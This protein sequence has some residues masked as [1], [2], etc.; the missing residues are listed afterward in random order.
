MSVWCTWL[1]ELATLDT[2]RTPEG[3]AMNSSIKSLGID[4]LPVEERLI[5]VEEIW[6]SIAA[7]SATARVTDAQR[8]ELQ[9]RIEEDDANRDD[10]APWEQ[11]KASTRAR[12]MSTRRP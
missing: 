11:V 1:A 10:V 3:Y 6:D 8:M 4:R 2:A 7:D 5:L 12:L 9:K